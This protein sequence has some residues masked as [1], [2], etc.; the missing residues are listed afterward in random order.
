M[1]S[2]LSVR[3]LSLEFRKNNEIVEVLRNVSFEIKQGEALGI[4][5]ESGSGKSVTAL[6]VMKLLPNH[7]KITHG[8]IIFQGESLR[9]TPEKKMEGIRGK[10]I[11]MIFQ[12]PMTSLNP[13]LKCGYQ[14]EEMFLTHFRQKKSY[15]NEVIELLK[16]VQIDHPERVYDSY[17]HQISGGQKQRVMIAMAIA[18]RPDLLIADEP[19]TALDVTV[20]KGILDLLKN[21]QKKYGMSM[22]F[23]SHDLAV[24]KDICNQI[25]VMWNGKIMETG[26]THQI[27]NQPKNAYTQALIN[28]R[29]KPNFYPVRLP[30]LQDFLE[31]QNDKI[32]S[33]NPHHLVFFDK[34]QNS[35][36]NANHEEV[37]KVE[38][39]SLWY[40]YQ[41]NIWGKVITWKKAVKEVSFSL[42]RG[43][44]LGLVGE[45]G[46]GKS[47]L[48]K[49][50]VYLLKP[51]SGSIYLQNRPVNFHSNRELYEYRKKIQM[52]FQ[53][54]YASLN[55]RLTIGKAIMEPM[56]YHKIYPSKEQC[57]QETC[58]L[59]EKVGLKKEHFDRLPHEF[60]GGQRQRIAIA[61]A[62]ALQPQILICDE[63]VSA[64]DVSVQAQV[65][66]LLNDLKQDFDLSF[67]FISHD[68]NVVQYFCD[69][70]LVMNQGEIVEEGFAHEILNRP[71][72]AYTQE[73]ISS[74]LSL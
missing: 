60:S 55:P 9:N 30:V 70:I 54:P 39:L 40:P 21:L 6:S 10:K 44:S 61:R 17:P 52:I 35:Q 53:D 72:H 51:T 69:R 65:L 26:D 49:T 37:L 24:I 36:I 8:D 74:V 33:K 67:I 25:V 13:V 20:Q 56:V 2:I 7:A 45:S 63:S 66:N 16:E 58:N 41:K 3:N 14:I 22:M 42:K 32:I 23:I 47:T 1:Q 57:Y 64:L 68:L 29:P 4:V 31:I 15:K 27:L 43:E 38:K 28:C 11:T 46:C 71:Q 12:E 19:T 18:T 5:G 34:I 62:L 73:L 59:L 50:L 48:A